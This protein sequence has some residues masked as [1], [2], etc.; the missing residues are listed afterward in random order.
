MYAK[1]GET[2]DFICRQCGLYGMVDVIGM[3]F[4]YDQGTGVLFDVI[5]DPDG[6]RKG[7]QVV[8]DCGSECFDM[9]IQGGN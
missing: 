3:E 9:R 7:D 5:D 6:R 2:R 1:F 8:C 4:V